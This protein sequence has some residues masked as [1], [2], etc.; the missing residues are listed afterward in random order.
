MLL[1][2]AI[3][4]PAVICIQGRG[5]HMYRAH[6]MVRRVDLENVGAHICQQIQCWLLCKRSIIFNLCKPWGYEGSFIGRI[7][8]RPINQATGIVIQSS[9]DGTLEITIFQN[10]YVISNIIIG[11]YVVYVLC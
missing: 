11:D 3:Y 4:R 9:E 8:F 10:E 2:T 6:C 7:Y 1:F 5:D